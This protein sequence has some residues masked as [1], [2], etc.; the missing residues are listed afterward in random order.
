MSSEW[1]ARRFWSSVSIAEEERGHAILLDA[2]RLKTPGKAPLVVPSRAL[3]EALAAEWDTQQDQIRPECMPLTRAVNT[4]I[5]GVAPRRAA[6]IDE[7]AGYGGSDLLCYRAPAPKSLRM[8]QARAWDPLL[9]WAE[10][11]LGAPLVPVT[12]VMPHPQ[13][14]ASLSALRA[15]VARFTPF[16][17]VGLHDLV[18]LS[19]SLVIGLATALGRDTPIAL[20]QVS[21]LDEE[22]Q[23]EQWGQDAEAGA[24]AAER[25]AGFEQAARLLALLGEAARQEPAR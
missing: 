1:K 7:I 25:R 13:P 22:W 18:A 23:A 19:G 14:E 11:D 5:D 20:W 17:L 6:V 2:R 3:A 4:A 8:Q 21:R 16:G 12:G 15:E 24:L 10:A 9:H